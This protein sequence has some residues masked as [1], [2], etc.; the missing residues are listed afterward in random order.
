MF[1]DVLI[2]ALLLRTKPILA[3][4]KVLQLLSVKVP[5][6]TTTGA[7]RIV[8]LLVT[9]VDEP[10]IVRF[11]TLPRFKNVPPVILVFVEILAKAPTVKQDEPDWLRTGTVLEIVRHPP[12]KS[13]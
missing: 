4:V 7:T 9:D 8:P 3:S 11:V 6:F 12:L 2:T 13:A 10:S 5:L 1:A